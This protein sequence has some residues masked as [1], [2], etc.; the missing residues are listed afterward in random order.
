MAVAHA[1]LGMVPAIEDAE[2]AS[3]G[4]LVGE[5]H[6][7][8][9]ENAALLVEHHMGA[10]RDGFMLLDLLFPKPRVVEAEVQV[11]ILQVAFAGLVADR[12]IE[13]VIRKEKLQHR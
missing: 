8:R 4:N 5:T 1:H 10:N 11:E 9:A 12:A 13:R 2:L 3:L 7:P 6:A